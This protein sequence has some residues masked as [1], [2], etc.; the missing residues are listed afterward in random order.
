MAGWTLLVI[1]VP[2]V[3]ALI[4]WVTR[5]YTRTDAEQAFLAEQDRRYQ[6]A[7]KPPGRGY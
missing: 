5:K 2:L 1:V 4:Y 3:G 6:A 7:H